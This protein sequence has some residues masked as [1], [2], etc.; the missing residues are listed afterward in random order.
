MPYALKV[1]KEIAEK[2]RRRLLKKGLLAS[3]W[4]IVYD[5]EYLYFPLQE[6][7]EGSV[8]M[9]MPGRKEKES[10]YD[11]VKKIVGDVNIPRHWE[12]IG[13][14][15]L[16]PPFENYEKYGETVGAA[17]SQVMGVKTVAIY[18]GVEG[19]LRIPRI[20]VIYGE[21]TET[22]HIENG[23]K[24]A[25]DVSR[26]M[27]SSGNVEE[28]IRMS[29]VDAEGE[30][31]VDMF[32]GIGYFSLPLAKYGGASKIYACEKNPVAFHYLLKN[33][34]INGVS[35][36]VPLFGDNRKNAPKNI[37][38]RVILGYVHTEKFLDTGIEALKDEGGVI[39]YHDTFTTEE[40]AWKPEK[41]VEEHASRYGFEVK[42]MFK[43]TVKSYAPHI[44]HVVVD[45]RLFPK[46]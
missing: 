13:D 29:R 8:Y 44:W 35:S 6:K 7:I 18:H 9:D 2:V 34:R 23:I 1:K 45:A 36:I 39:H 21:D 30:V 10:P 16:L 11:K 19:E 5:G 28:R 24:Y 15:L 26:V 17:F 43:R 25:L 14:V 41:I 46:G 12:K 40:R 42:I 38:D 27:F 37:A 22:V 4:S 3:Q 20:E 31:I 33:I 32:A